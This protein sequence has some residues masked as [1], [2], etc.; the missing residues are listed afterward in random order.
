MDE[1]I[2]KL[3]K[4][5][6]EDL[7][8]SEIMIE[9]GI[10][11][12]AASRVYYAMFY[13]VEALLLTKGLI[14]TSHKGLISSFNK[15]FIKSGIF[16]IKFGRLLRDAFDIRQNSDYEIVP[17]ITESKTKELLLLAKEFLEEAKKYLGK[18]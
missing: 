16:N 2:E 15:E 10:Y 1:R 3:L 7:K 13:I 5:A 8:A 6:Q 4:K 12:I 17:D 11:R 14:F 18:R 9:N